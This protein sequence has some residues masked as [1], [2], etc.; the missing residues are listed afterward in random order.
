MV[1]NNILQVLKNKTF[2]SRI[3]KKLGEPCKVMTLLKM[4]FL[5]PFN[6]Y[7]KFLL[8]SY[9]HVILFF[10]YQILQTKWHNV[11][12]K[13]EPET[14]TKYRSKN[15]LKWERKNRL[16]THHKYKR[17]QI[18]GIVQSQRTQKHGNV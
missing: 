8:L 10:R 11:Q 3:L 12:N 18:L 7:P 4:K 6:R 5:R 1:I 15:E 14:E 2:P 13:N 9:C 16:D 17:N